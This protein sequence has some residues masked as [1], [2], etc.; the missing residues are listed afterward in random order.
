MRKRQSKA[1]KTTDGRTREYESIIA[2]LEILADRGLTE[3]LLKLSKTLDRDVAAG[4]LLTIADVFG[5]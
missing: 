1:D 3:R 2:T 5:T 4:S